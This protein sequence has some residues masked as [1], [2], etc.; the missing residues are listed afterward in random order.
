MKDRLPVEETI[1]DLEALAAMLKERSEDRARLAET[2]A[3]QARVCKEA[4]LTISVL[5]TK[6]HAVR[7]ADE[8]SRREPRPVCVGCD[9]S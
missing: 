2:F 6:L 7:A 1:E 9:D 8:P 4:R 3:D 5:I